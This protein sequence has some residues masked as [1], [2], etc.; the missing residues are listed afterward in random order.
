LYS[1]SK[2]QFDADILSGILYCDEGFGGRNEDGTFSNLVTS[3][4]ED[5]VTMLNVFATEG[6]SFTDSINLGNPNISGIIYIHN[7]NKTYGEDEILALQEKYP[8]LTFFFANVNKAYSA[9]F[10]IFNPDDFS[11]TYVK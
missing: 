6:N 1:F 11:E 8:N 4:N 9:K 7:T 10:V 2:K 3:I 5:T